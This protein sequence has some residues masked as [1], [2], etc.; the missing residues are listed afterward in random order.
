MRKFSI[1]TISDVES[2][3]TL[4]LGL[5]IRWYYLFTIKFKN[6]NDIRNGVK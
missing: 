1:T 3:R 5:I 4:F 6:K 2:M